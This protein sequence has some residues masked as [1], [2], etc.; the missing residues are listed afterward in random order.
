MA[1][2][3]ALVAQL[4]GIT[5]QILALITQWLSALYTIVVQCFNALIQS[6]QILGD[7]L[8]RGMSQI[9]NQVNQIYQWLAEI[10]K[11]IRSIYSYLTPIARLAVTLAPVAVLLAATV[12]DPAGALNSFFKLII[13]AIVGQMPSTP[14][15]Y[16]IGSLLGNLIGSLPSE[17]AFIGSWL[18]DT[19]N[20]IIIMLNLFLFIKL[21]KL[22]PFF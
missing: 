18:S 21:I 3:D 15:N 1:V 8:S 17:I 6:L 9:V 13:D 5:N 19:M 22:L 7:L 2:F 4:L 11:Y 16:K 10:V 20:G 14:E 12:A